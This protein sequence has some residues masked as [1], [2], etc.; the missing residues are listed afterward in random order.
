MRLLRI[1]QIIKDKQPINKRDLQ[2]EIEITEGMSESLVKKYLG[3]LFRR[4]V[5]QVSEENY[6]TLVEQK[7]EEYID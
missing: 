1:K 2:D 6:V 5:I 7:E 4:G 3:L